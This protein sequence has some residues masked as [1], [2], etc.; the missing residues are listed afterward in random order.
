MNNIIWMCWFQG[1][2][3]KSI[4]SLQKICI[5]KWRDLNPDCEV[6]VLTDNNIADYV[7][8]FFQIVKD[9]LERT[10]QARSDLLR[11]LLLSKYGGTWVD[12]TIYPT[13]PL[14]EF[15][16]KIVNNTGFFTYRYLPR[17][18]SSALGNRET[19]SWFICA[20]KPNQYIIERWKCNFIDEFKSKSI[21]PYFTFHQTL[22]D[23]YDNDM[24]VK[25]IIDNM[26]QISE[27]IPHSACRDSQKTWNNREQSYVYKRP[28]IN[29]N[30]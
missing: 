19:V 23:L 26:V 5:K 30:K 7:P 14:S 20:D 3:H 17:S 29:L 24:K 11:L 4:G 22:A 27:K 16:N 28:N 6:N 21:W 13:Q 9:S 18:T 10:Y 1:E 25:S 2:D 12:A 15:Y 8:E